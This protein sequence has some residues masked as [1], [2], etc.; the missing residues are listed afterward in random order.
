MCA[1]A[2]T[3]QKRVS[4]QEETGGGMGGEGYLSWQQQVV[5]V[6]EALM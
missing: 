6:T 4:Q 2:R 3:W 5:N 1:G